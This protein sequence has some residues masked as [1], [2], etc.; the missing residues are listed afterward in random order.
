MMVEREEEGGMVFRAYHCVITRPIVLRPDPSAL[1]H[2]SST[3]NEI[4]LSYTRIYSVYAR[5]K[6]VELPTRRS[7]GDSRWKHSSGESMCGPNFT[8]RTCFQATTWNLLLTILYRSVCAF[9]IDYIFKA[10]V[11][12]GLSFRA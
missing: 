1:D 11:E 8:Y 7:L 12:L 4:P 10:K 2:R 9:V 6:Y 3:T 5:L